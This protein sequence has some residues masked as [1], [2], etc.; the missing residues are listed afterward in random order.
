MQK[1]TK[2]RKNLLYLFE[3]YSLNKTLHFSKPQNLFL[4]TF[5]RLQSGK[6]T[7]EYVKFYFKQDVENR[8]IS[9]FI[10]FCTHKKKPQNLFFTRLYGVNLHLGM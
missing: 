10:A 3:G 2:N 5:I 7:P 8:N 9:C 6:S 4:T 1:Q